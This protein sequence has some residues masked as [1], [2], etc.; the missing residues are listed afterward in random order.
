M[1]KMS[2]VE[3]KVESD[4]DIIIQKQRGRQPDFLKSI[5]KRI[6]AE[7]NKTNTILE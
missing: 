6:I 1:R 4:A 5:N 2:H 3:I 7:E